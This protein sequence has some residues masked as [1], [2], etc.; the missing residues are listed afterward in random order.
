MN[1]DLDPLLRFCSGGVVEQIQCLQRQRYL[2]S[3]LFFRRRI[4]PMAS[5]YW[6]GIAVADEAQQAVGVEDML[7]SIVVDGPVAEWL[8]W[9]DVA[10]AEGGGRGG[11]E[12]FEAYC[13]LLFFASAVNRST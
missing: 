13:A 8:R 4:E 2:P 3:L 5:A 9:C 7:A 6:A 12:W 10:L 1:R 11:E